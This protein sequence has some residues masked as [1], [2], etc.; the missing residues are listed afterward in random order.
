MVPVRTFCPLFCPQM[1]DEGRLG[2]LVAV[3]EGAVREEAFGVAAQAA[4]ALEMLAASR[5]MCARI[6]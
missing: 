6:G 1:R 2:A 4:W 3:L 5:R